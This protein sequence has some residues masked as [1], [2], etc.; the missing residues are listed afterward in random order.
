MADP[1]V[2]AAY[3]RSAM[4]EAN[5]RVAPPQLYGSDEAPGLSGWHYSIT[6][7]DNPD[8]H[9]VGIH[10]RFQRVLSETIEAPSDADVFAIACPWRNWETAG[11]EGYVAAYID[12]SSRTIR[13]RQFS[14]MTYDTKVNEHDWIT[15][16][17]PDGS[18]NKILGISGNNSHNGAGIVRIFY[19]GGS[20]DS[21]DDGYLLAYRFEFGDPIYTTFPPAA[22]LYHQKAWGAVDD[23]DSS[24]PIYD[25]PRFPFTG[26]EEF[27]FIYR[28]SN[29]DWF[30]RD[31]VTQNEAAL[32][33]EP[34][35]YDGNNVWLRN[36]DNTVSVFRVGSSPGFTLTNIGSLSDAFTGPIDHNFRNTLYDFVAYNTFFKI[37][38]D[39]FFAHRGEE[40]DVPG[41]LRYATLPHVSANPIAVGVA[42]QDAS[43][44]HVN[45]AMLVLYDDGM[46]I[47]VPYFRMSADQTPSG[48]VSEYGYTEPFLLIPN[49]SKINA[50][51]L[52]AEEP[53]NAIAVKYGS[54]WRLEVYALGR[55]REITKKTVA[56]SKY[57]GGLSIWGTDP[58]FKFFGESTEEYTMPFGGGILSDGLYKKRIFEFYDER[59]A[60][61]KLEGGLFYKEMFGDHGPRSL[62]TIVGKWIAGGSGHWIDVDP[63]WYNWAAA[64]DV[65]AAVPQ[66]DG[67]LLCFS[68]LVEWA[69][70]G[71]WSQSK[72]TY[73][74]KID[75][76]PVEGIK[77]VDAYNVR[78][79]YDEWLGNGDPVMALSQ[80]PDGTYYA[81][82][83]YGNTFE[84]VQLN[85]SFDLIRRMTIPH[86]DAANGFYWVGFGVHPESGNLFLHGLW[87]LYS[88]DTNGTQLNVWPWGDPNDNYNVF[89]GSD[90]GY[91][92]YVYW[93]S[94]FAAGE[95]MHKPVFD[96]PYVF[97]AA[98]DVYDPS[99][100]GGGW[101][102]IRINIEDPNWSRSPGDL[103]MARGQ[104][105][106]KD[107]GWA[108]GLTLIDP[109]IPQFVA[110]NE[111][112][113]LPTVFGRPN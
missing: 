97:I 7:S 42:T 103:L 34:L 91:S 18:A 61:W 38:N 73:F 98:Y 14:Y 90:S 21:S 108:G 93:E 76:D 37:G 85:S 5:A 29:G 84:I 51:H 55:H 45:H 113:R 9:M 4:R 48:R 8:E 46:A 92:R 87:A 31:V 26:S 64:Y 104:P 68:R 65:S 77:V 22:T 67:L 32:P 56:F 112:I 27:P 49:A 78:D 25:H 62:S 6:G 80:H 17:C 100:N 89:S 40:N 30:V 88:F 52:T 23:R 2:E 47:S 109:Q 82:V 58:D 24:Y 39:I 75:S 1:V 107:A 101:G 35:Q 105:S 11:Y 19:E 110:S 44:A 15:I 20:T 94:D 60:V 13:L 57:W 43:S 70:D 99:W 28:K 53:M 81:A 16:S 79:G 10:N 96:G 71:D 86:P 63:A 106:A 36:T 69:P 74:L 3:S 102:I 72:S 54:E 12:P 41:D 95:Y 59:F 33:G 83:G 66:E 111:V 50:S